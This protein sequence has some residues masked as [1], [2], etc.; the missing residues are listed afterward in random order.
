MIVNELDD[1]ENSSVDTALIISDTKWFKQSRKSSFARLCKRV[2]YFSV[3]FLVTASACIL[4][5]ALYAGVF[6]E[7]RVNNLLLEAENAFRIFDANVPLINET[8]IEV[9]KMIHLAKTIETIF[10]NACKKY[11]WLCE[12]SGNASSISNC[13]EIVFRIIN[14]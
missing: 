3:L 9:K 11:P 12:S 7:P 5:T 10:E 1:T 2:W 8:V 4:S 13:S 6:F 14:V